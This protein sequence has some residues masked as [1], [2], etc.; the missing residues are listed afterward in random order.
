MPDLAIRVVDVYVFRRTAEGARWLLLRRAPD[1]L[2]AGTWRMIGGKIEPGET[3]WQ[4]A[5]RET[6]EETGREPIA[7]WALPSV[8]AFY[9]WHEDRLTLAPAFAAEVVDDPVLNAEH[10][11]C[12]WLDA[13]AAAAR[14]AW[15]EQQRLI[16]L[17]ADL[18]A[19]EA[20]AS[21]LRVPLS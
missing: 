19:R 9:E 16:R 11:A 18:V 10:D 3:A 12:A 2:Y 20:F 4:A 17:A 1:R 5:L 6:R 7:L 8:N 15:P 14:L 21:E 13:E